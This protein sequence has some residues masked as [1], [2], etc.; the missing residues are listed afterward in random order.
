MIGTKEMRRVRGLIHHIDLTVIE[1][2]RSRI[3]Y[4]HFLSFIG[5]ARSEDHENGTDWD[6][7]GSG[8]FASIGIIKAKGEHA[9]R[10]HD[11]G[12]AGLHH[13]AFT[14]ESRADV[15][16]L[17]TK[18][19]EIEAVILD[20]PALY[21]RYH[22]DYYALFFNDPDGLKLEYVFIGK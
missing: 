20:P 18:L 1:L 6:R 10:V 14:A 21:P 4:D 15:N 3:F 8:P 2:E 16:L 17:Y 11:R 22:T 9:A 13:L 5:Y 7:S 12:S 19:L